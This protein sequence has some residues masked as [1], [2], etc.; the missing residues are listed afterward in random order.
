[1]PQFK[2]YGRADSL[3]PIRTQLSDVIHSCAQETLGL[4]ENKRF[5]RFL[6]LDPEDFI[7]SERTPQYLIIEV[8][9]FEGRS[10]D[11]KK[12]LLRLLMARIHRQL[13]I[14]VNDIEITLIET[15][16]QNWGIRGM[17]GDELGLSYKVDV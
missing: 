17:T 12:Q 3:Q 16:K 1:M 4:P 10:L 9:M 13:G 15:P 2:I 8:V 14:P 11:T 5:Q 7:Y 6:M